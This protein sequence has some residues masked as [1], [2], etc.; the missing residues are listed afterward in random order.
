MSNLSNIPGGGGLPDRY[1]NVGE[2][3]QAFFDFAETDPDRAVPF[4]VNIW[5]TQASLTTRALALQGLGVA[6][7]HYRVKEAFAD[8][9]VLKDIAKEV[10]GK[11]EV[12][13]DLTRWAA[14]SALEAI[15][16]SRQSLE[17]LQGG[18]FTEPLDRIRREIR[19]RKFIEINRIPRLN[20]RG[21]TTAEYER[22]LEFWIYGPADELLNDR[23]RSLNYQDLV[24]DVISKLHGRGVYLGLISP[25]S[26]V[27]GAALRQAGLIFKESAQIEKFIYGLLEEFLYN[28]NH[29]VSLR[30]TATKI[31]HTATDLSKKL[32]TLSK[33]LSQEKD[34]K[35]LEVVLHHAQSLFMESVDNQKFIYGYL[36]QF[37]ID[38]THEVSVRIMAIEIITKASGLKKV[39]TLS[40]LLLED[41]PLQNVALRQIRL[42]FKESSQ[43]EELLFETLDQFL[44]YNYEVS[45]KIDAAELVYTARNL[46]KKLTTVSKL[47]LEDTELRNLAVRLLTP[48]KQELARVNADAYTVL[49]ALVFNYTLKTWQKPELQES[50]ISQLATYLS[51]AS[52]RQYKEIFP[53]ISMPRTNSG[54]WNYESAVKYSKSVVWA[55]YLQWMQ[56]SAIEDNEKSDNPLRMEIKKLVYK[57]LTISQLETNLSSAIQ[58][59]R[60]IS[61]IFTSAIGA[62]ESLG[63][64]YRKS[65]SLL[66]G[67]LQNKHEDVIKATDEKSTHPLRE[68]IKELV[69]IQNSI[70][71]YQSFLKR[72]PYRIK[73]IDSNLYRKIKNFSGFASL[74]H[75]KKIDT[76]NDCFQTFDEL[77][78]LRDQVFFESLDKR[79]EVW[80]Q[81]SEQEDALNKL[82]NNGC[83]VIIALIFMLLIFML[84]FRDILIILFIMI[85]LIVLGYKLLISHLNNKQKL[86]EALTDDLCD[87]PRWWEK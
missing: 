77:D 18:G 75:P 19:D 13:N 11:G 21:E 46:N 86:I 60:E 4:F 73:S 67:C 25:N 14:A 49:D 53:I 80:S 58:Y 52:Q 71:K 50:K 47:L 32:K 79:S 51:S 9:D 48:Y 40:K 83:L 63:E 36:E 65:A 81:Q 76:Y 20:S 57:D 17:N 26:I 42:I 82:V 54:D 74:E 15:G 16:Y 3:I 5:E 87:L 78:S 23:D 34:A 43:I 56:E 59:Q 70:K 68:Q 10:K 72:I 6:A 85:G 64:K 29:E 12:S 62:A 31:I 8:W 41:I 7:K 66:T 39:E 69:H 38:R 84:I 45:L 35:L 33:L 27:Q 1:R 2:Q 28:S 55:E 37:L 61:A 24:G 22:H 30:I 44:N